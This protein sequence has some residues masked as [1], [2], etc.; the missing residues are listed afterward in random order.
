MIVAGNDAET[1]KFSYV[2]GK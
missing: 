2:T 1:Q